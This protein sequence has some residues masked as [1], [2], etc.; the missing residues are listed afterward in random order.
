[1]CCV[2]RLIEAQIDILKGCS[3]EEVH[4]TTNFLNLKI[5]HVHPLKQ[6]NM[7]DIFPVL[8]ILE[9]VIIWCQ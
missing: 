5:E 3:S 6:S 2:K 1:M 4:Q 8:G 7:Y 9:L